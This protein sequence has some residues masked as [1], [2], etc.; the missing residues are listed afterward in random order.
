MVLLFRVGSQV[1]RTKWPCPRANEGTSGCVNR[2]WS[3]GQERRTNR[4]PDQDRKYE[5]THDT[6]ACRFYD[7]LLNKSPCERIPTVCPWCALMSHV[8]PAQQTVT[9]DA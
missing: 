2:F 7:R 1:L 5:L 8:P 6:F 4:L 9:D 3:D